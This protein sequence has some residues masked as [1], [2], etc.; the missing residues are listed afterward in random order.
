MDFRTLRYFVTV[1]EELN[2]TKAALRLNMSQPPLSNQMRQ[3]EEELGVTLFIRGKRR[4]KLTEAGKLLYQRARQIL[5][6]GTRTREELTDM[7]KELSGRLC[8]GTVEG[9]APFLAA[10]LIAGF[11]EEYPLVRYTMRNG[12]SDDL[13]EQLHQ[14]IIDL[15]VIATPY[16]REN[17][18][19][20]SL[21]FESWAAIIPAGHPLA[22]HPSDPLPVR[23]LSGLP[24]IVPER[25]SRIKEI[26]EWLTQAGA[27]VS[28]LCTL[29]H[30]MDAIALVDQGIGIDRKSVV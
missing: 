18:E 13:L 12:S 28:I 25:P 29:S 19:G 4:L 16:D 11:R 14:G 9:R 27:E 24:L 1:A 8:L 5:E 3:L 21:G 23:E 17:L 26:T 22:S 20:I 7:G 30:Y 6:M 15:A 10:R 2:I